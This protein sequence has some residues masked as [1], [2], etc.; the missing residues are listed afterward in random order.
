MSETNRSHPKALRK[1][2][3]QTLAVLPIFGKKIILG[4]SGGSDSMALL[5]VL[6]TLRKDFN[7][8][9]VACGVNHNLR[10]EASQ[11]LIIAEEF[12]KSLNVVFFKRDIYLNN[13]GNIQ[14]RAR[15]A[16]YAALRGLKESIKADYICTAHH[17]EDKA[18]TV[19]MRIIR[20][21]SV[22]GLNVL[23]PMSGDLLRPMI[24]AKKRDVMLHITRKSIP[25]SDDPSNLKK[26]VYLRSKIRMELI[27]FL[28]EINPNIVDALCE[29]SKS[30][31]H[32]DVKGLRKD[33]RKIISN[34]SSRG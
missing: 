24:E 6:A 22:S 11:E 9:L 8:E 14:E 10:T 34:L 18:E 17:A 28:T 7:F 16:R 32:P 5:H 25:Y 2:V 26:D 31:K 33:R 3:K 4:L 20:G 21:T 15:D 12:C 19:L 29:L 23:E 30:A 13:G 27:P 1:T